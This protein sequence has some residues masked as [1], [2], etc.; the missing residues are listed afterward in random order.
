MPSIEFDDERPPRG[1]EELLAGVRRDGLRRRHWRHG[2]IGGLALVLVA[3]LA[4][5]VVAGGDDG[6]S[7]PQRVAVLDEAPD[8]TVADE[9]TTTST[10]VEETTTTVARPPTTERRTTGSTTTARTGRPSPATTVTTLT[11]RNSFDERCGPFRWDPDPG[12]NQAAQVTI[13]FTPST[14]RAGQEVTAH[15]TMTDPD[16]PAAPCS[17][18]TKWG[19]DKPWPINACSAIYCAQQ[20][21]G[22]WTPPARASDTV[23]ISQAHTYDAPGTFTVTFRGW[24]TSRGSCDAPA[25]PY[26]SDKTG[27]ATV[28]VRP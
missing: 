18:E 7:D 2:L 4:I 23:E 21:Y 25:N 3:A 28:T 6:G 17:T 8:T 11:C 19:D 10:V 16:G 13:T 12:A 14:P 15:I 20:P 9:T 27:S 22:P 5:P 26:G 1:R 24:G